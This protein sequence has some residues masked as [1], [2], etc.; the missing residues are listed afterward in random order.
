MDILG[1]SERFAQYVLSGERRPGG[2]KAL[3]LARRLGV[4]LEAV[5]FPQEHGLDLEARLSALMKQETHGHEA[6]RGGRQADCAQGSALRRRQDRAG[7][8]R[9]SS[10]KAGAG[11]GR[12]SAGGSWAHSPEA[13]GRADT[14]LRGEAA[15]PCAAWHSPYP[16]EAWP[17]GGWDSGLDEGCGPAHDGKGGSVDARS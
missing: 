17:Y 5:L 15:Q 2:E 4:P 12:N 16:G 7:K 8:A 14:L 6:G 1:S 9:G 3:R 13:E 10:S 11:A